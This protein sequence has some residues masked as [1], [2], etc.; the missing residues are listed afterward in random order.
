MDASVTSTISDLGPLYFAPDGLIYVAGFTAGQLL[1]TTPNALLEAPCS[2]YGGGLVVVFNAQGQ[3]QMLSYLPGAGDGVS[4]FYANA[5]GS[6]SANAYFGV[7]ILIDLSQRP[8]AGCVVDFIDATDPSARID[9]PTPS[10]FAAGEILQVLGG[11]FGPNAPATA[12]PAAGQIY[13]ISLGG[14]SVQVAGI[15]A[16]ILASGPGTAT[17][18]IPFETPAGAAVPV[19]VQC[20]GQQSMAFPIAVQPVAPW[21]DGWVLNADGTQN[22]LQN[23]AAWGSVLTIYASGLGNYSPPLA[24]GQIAP[25]DKSHSLQLPV[26]ISFVATTPAPFPGTIVYAGPAPGQIGLA[27]IQFQLPAS[28]PEPAAGQLA[29]QLETQLTIG[30]FLEYVPSISVK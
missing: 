28:G 4:S 9:Y 11:G 8:K 3:V 5:D 1:T 22:T 16:P 7:P 2:T 18:Q 6:V 15:P 20:G 19:T 12:S 21:P 27:E 13:P 25:N 14:V 30:S 10:T 24:D 26:S 29:T 17:F 23:P